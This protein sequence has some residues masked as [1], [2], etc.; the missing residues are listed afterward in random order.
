MSTTLVEKLNSVLEKYGDKDFDRVSI[1]D[2]RLER[3]GD[4]LTCIPQPDNGSR[5]FF[6][7]K[8]SKATF[9]RDSDPNEL[10]YPHPLNPS[11]PNDDVER[12]LTGWARAYMEVADVERHIGEGYEKYKGRPYANLPQD[13]MILINNETTFKI[14]KDNHEIYLH[15]WSDE[16]TK[17]KSYKGHFTVLDGKVC[18]TELKQR[19]Y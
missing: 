14:S 15:P 6:H 7:V 18:V 5:K 16:E 9:S 11:G 4:F 1:G 13:S 17:P 19:E 10:F 12:I 2:F 8:D 3:K